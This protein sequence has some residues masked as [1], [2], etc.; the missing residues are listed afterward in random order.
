[1]GLIELIVLGVLAA[2]FVI[3][4]GADIVAWSKKEET[5]VG[6]DLSAAGKTVLTDVQT[7]AKY[8]VSMVET[9]VKDVEAKF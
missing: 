1:M 6:S 5:V 2:D 9:G 4:R 8:V 3:R 7:G